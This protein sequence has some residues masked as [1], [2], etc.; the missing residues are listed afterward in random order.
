[1]TKII[2]K[3]CIY[4]CGFSEAMSSLNFEPVKHGVRASNAEQSV[5]RRMNI[6]LENKYDALSR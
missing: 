1:M 6:D 2:L 3:K 4:F 5:N